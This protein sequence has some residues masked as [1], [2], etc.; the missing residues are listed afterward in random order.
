MKTLS[1]ESQ[2]M[3][4]MIVYGIGFGVAAGIA[5]GA[6]VSLLQG[7]DMAIASNGRFLFAIFTLPF[8]GIFF[9]ALYGLIGGLLL[10][11]I[12][13]LVIGI[14]TGMYFV[15]GR[16]T[17]NYQKTATLFTLGIC[18]IIGGLGLLLVNWKDLS[19]ATVVWIM[20]VIIASVM[21]Y[22]ATQNVVIYYLRTVMNLP[23]VSSLH[24]VG[25]Q[26]RG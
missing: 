2:I 10:A 7:L 1:V 23:P 22:K 25:E 20:P 17:R 3:L 15:K 8:F 26:P 16:D 13:G 11:I 12:V 5:Y 19:M 4:R 9:G 14:V 18:A 21:C 24:L 6:A